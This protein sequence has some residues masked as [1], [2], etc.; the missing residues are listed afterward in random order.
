MPAVT[1]YITLGLRLGRHIDGMVDAYYGPPE[2]KERVD[3][4]PVKAPAA[5]VDDARSLLADMDDLDA[6]RRHWLRAQAEGLHTTAR[7]LAGLFRDNFR[8]YEGGV[9]AEARQGEPVA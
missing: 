9:S 1:G 8:A 2:L 5:L 3:A 6:G 4:E 7:K